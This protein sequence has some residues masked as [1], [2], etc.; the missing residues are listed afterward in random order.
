MVSLGPSGVGNKSNKNLTCESLHVSNSAHIPSAFISNIEVKTINGKLF[1]DPASQE[2]IETIKQEMEFIKNEI[3]A[4]RKSMGP[5]SPYTA[6]KSVQVTVEFK[7]YDINSAHNSYYFLNDVKNAFLTAS[8]GNHV[9]ILLTTEQESS[10]EI[11]VEV[12]F[13]NREASAEDFAAL[14]LQ[15]QFKKCDL[16][17]QNPEIRDRY[18]DYDVLQTEVGP[19]QGIQAKIASAKKKME[20]P[21]I[22]FTKSS[23]LALGQFKMKNDPISGAL[24][25]QRYDESIG[26]YVGGTIITD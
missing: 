3:K 20:A 13:H 21:I 24:F 19:I 4:I 2:D 6:G 11:V 14:A 1:D 22:D 18:G 26:E 23:A 10:T 9:A 5:E 25:I 8:G 15:S 16:F 7:D 17:A 12:Q